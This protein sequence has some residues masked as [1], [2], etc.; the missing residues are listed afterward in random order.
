MRALSISVRLPL[1]GLAFGEMET[2]L[3]A[4]PK[5]P[6]PHI[7]SQGSRVW[8]GGFPDRPASLGLCPCPVLSR[9]GAGQTGDAHF[10]THSPLWPGSGHLEKPVG[11]WAVLTTSAGAGAPFTLPSLAVRMSHS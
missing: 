5:A 7:Y 3:P 6:T 4:W 10:S 2:I 11:T 9:S 8:P 1:G